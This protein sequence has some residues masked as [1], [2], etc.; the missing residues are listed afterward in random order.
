MSPES[1]V[2]VDAGGVFAHPLRTVLT[3]TFVVGALDAM[4][5]RLF[6]VFTAN[7]AGNLVVIW[8]SLVGDRTTALLSLASL[9]GCAI[10]VV[11]V[12]VFRHAWP[13]LAGPTGSRVLLVVSAL[14]TVL[15]AYLGVTVTGQWHLLS[16]AIAAYSVAVL[17]MVF[18]SADGLRAPV[19]ASTNA[20]V[21]AIRY[22]MASRL[23][24]A[25]RLWPGLAVRAAGFPLAWTLGAALAA[26]VPVSSFVVAVGAA[27]LVIGVALF[28]RRVLDASAADPPTV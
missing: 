24:P 8:T 20:F 25:Q 26:F 23:E 12:V 3:I 19:L 5:F 14:L 15:A 4:S 27:L 9:I 11:S 6:G 18:I 22:G 1:L 17:G 28:S 7:Q 2:D 13:W 21:D 16:V 10:G